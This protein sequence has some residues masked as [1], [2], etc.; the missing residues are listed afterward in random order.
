MEVAKIV[1]NGQITIPAGVRE[2]LSLQ[3]GDKIVFFE[4][5]GQ[6]Y[7]ENAALFAITSLQNAF[8]GEAERSGFENEDDVTAMVKKIRNERWEER[9]KK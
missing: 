2:V 1:S 8:E 4:Q 9:K 6:F 7:I 3:D 5:D